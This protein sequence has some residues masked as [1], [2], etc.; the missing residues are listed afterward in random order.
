MKNG[1]LLIT[2]ETDFYSLIF[3]ML[4]S[5]VRLKLYLMSTTSKSIQEKRIFVTCSLAYRP[6]KFTNYLFEIKFADPT[7]GKFSMKLFLVM[8]EFYLFQVTYI[9]FCEICIAYI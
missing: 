1:N 5:Y 7:F 9:C 6:Q 4:V 8:V 3:Q 2:V